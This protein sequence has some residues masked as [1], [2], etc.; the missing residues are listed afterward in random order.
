VPPA[1][2]HDLKRLWYNSTPPQAPKGRQLGHLPDYQHV[3]NWNGVRKEL[4][5]PQ[6]DETN[7]FTFEEF[8]EE[9]NVDTSYD[10]TFALEV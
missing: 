10:Q 3:I 9:V 1:L 7:L 8:Y 2:K 6:V 4:V 5:P